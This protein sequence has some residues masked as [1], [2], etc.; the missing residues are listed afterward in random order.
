MW[1]CA[2]IREDCITFTLCIVQ[3][4]YVNIALL[5]RTSAR[6]CAHMHLCTCDCRL[7]GYIRIYILS[8]HFGFAINLPAECLLCFYEPA[9]RRACEF[10]HL[11]VIAPSRQ[12]HLERLRQMKGINNASKYWWLPLGTCMPYAKPMLMIKHSSSWL[13]APLLF[14]LCS[15]ILFLLSH[16]GHKQS[17][18]GRNCCCCCLCLFFVTRFLPLR[19]SA[20][21]SA[22]LR[23]FL[24]K[25][26]L[27]NTASPRGP[28][29]WK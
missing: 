28:L 5:S 24:M 1:S 18:L 13:T 21:T 29:V 10:A 8:C 22:Q 17:Q 20:K 14:L 6:L 4:H 12:G 25:A 3:L 15:L 11:S 19:C 16:S 23:E 26:A 7:H 9:S 2:D 27:D